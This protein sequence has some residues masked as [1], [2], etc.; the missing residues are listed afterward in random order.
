M[1]TRIAM[2]WIT[3]VLAAAAPAQAHFPGVFGR[4]YERLEEPGTTLPEP[5]EARRPLARM[6]PDEVARY[7]QL[8][9]QE[10]EG[11]GPYAPQLSE[12]LSTLA[13]LY[14]QAGRYAEAEALY[15]RA[16]HIERINDGL[17]GRGQL[18]LVET[19]LSMYREQGDLSRL[20]QAHDY[21]FRLLGSG[22]PPYSAER[23]QAALRYLSWQQEAVG[24]QLDGDNTG[25]LINAYRV[26]QQMLDQLA[27]E[28]HRDPRFHLRLVLSQLHNLYLIMGEERAD[29]QP[30]PG[31]LV[32]SPPP[33]RF[34]PAASARQRLK[35]LQN[36]GV[37][38]GR[39]LLTGY[40]EAWPDLEA[41]RRMVIQMELADWLQWN[42]KFQSA[43]EVYRDIIAELVQ[44]GQMDQYREWFAKP[45]ELPALD[46]FEP[47]PDPSPERP[48][49]EVVA[50]Y[51]VSARGNVSDIGVTAVDA[52]HQGR[53][54]RL[55]RLLRDGHFRPRFSP[56]GEREAAAVERSY[57]LYR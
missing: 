7:R 49:V 37:S 17:Q 1:S 44:T 2:V 56:E 57:R 42:L 9:E 45:V 26:N 28:P 12:P 46:V 18:A 29:E 3:L 8:L 50:S 23:S 32:G 4:D 6:D 14:R 43:Q 21:Y 48:P 31:N 47:I 52:E 39:K 54:H 53:A 36:V 27:A 13:L 51:R 22:Q 15:R 55:V 41:G 38:E 5:G 19:L 33:G 11:Y 30:P 16:L 34:G 10:G 40:L 25:R 24:R 20:D 35:L